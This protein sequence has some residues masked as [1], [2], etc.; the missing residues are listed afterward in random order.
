MR[1]SRSIASALFVLIPYGCKV[2]IKIKAKRKIKLG[3][4][5]SSRVYAL[6]L[7]ENPSAVQ[8]HFDLG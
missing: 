2:Q 8:Y 5:H 7:F 3:K 4:I 6:P 1:Y